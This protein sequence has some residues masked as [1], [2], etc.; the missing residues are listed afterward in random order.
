MVRQWVTEV[1]QVILDD[2]SIL[3]LGVYAGIQAVVFL[4][5][6]TLV[7]CINS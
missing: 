7:Y 6:C 4:L 2:L 5:I 1:I 3:Q